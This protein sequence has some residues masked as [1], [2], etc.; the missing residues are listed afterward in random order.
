MSKPTTVVTVSF[1]LVADMIIQG[2]VMNF[3]IDWPDKAYRKTPTPIILSYYLFSIIYPPHHLL[4][5][6]QNYV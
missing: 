4:L 1:A 3:I 6:A 2:D 5:F